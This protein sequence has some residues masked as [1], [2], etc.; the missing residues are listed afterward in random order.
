MT[1]E[2]M[3]EHRYVAALAVT[4]VDAAQCIPYGTMD[5]T[6]AH[7]GPW[8]AAV[9]GAFI[10]V[11]LLVVFS[12]FTDRLRLFTESVYFSAGLYTITTMTILSAEEIRS[13]PRFMLAT[14]FGG[15]TVGL[16][17]LWLTL[18]RTP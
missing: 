9:T 17:T 14:V 12:A 1:T 11:T 16:F 13:Q 10:L 18:R 2:T 4:L 15:V 5:L 3:H 7:L 8:E 6:Y